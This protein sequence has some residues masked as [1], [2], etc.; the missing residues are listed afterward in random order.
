MKEK[1]L[2]PNEQ[3]QMMLLPHYLKMLNPTKP[4]DKGRG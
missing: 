2:K 3:S 1:I 4:S